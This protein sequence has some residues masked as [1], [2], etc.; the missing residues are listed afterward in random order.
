MKIQEK[1]MQDLQIKKPKYELDINKVGVTGLLLP[2]KIKYNGQVNPVTANISAFVDLPKTE[3][4]TH[5]SRMIKILH[6]AS[7][8][9]LDPDEISN[10][11]KELKNQL[12]AHHSYLKIEFTLFKAKKSPVTKNEGFI[13]YKC[14]FNADQNA[15]MN[16]RL[17]AEVLVTSL[18]PIS[19]SVS[20]YSAHNQ[21]GKLIAEVLCNDKGIW[22]D[23]II[24]TLENGGS[25][26]L[27][28]VLKRE[29]E[30]YVTEKAYENPKIVE[31]IVREVASE[32]KK[33]KHIMELRVSC[34]NFESI[35]THN[36]YSEITLKNG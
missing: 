25:C 1:Q 31:D 7:S 4:G 27:F 26:E 20:K 35:H 21:R 9:E 13:S 30:K 14:F 34:E 32:L 2:L 33:N 16:L 18:C 23:E 24:D 17:G 3:R 28:S 19:K 36:A 8:K 29:D 22:F 11:L 10:I 6:N 12:N 5:M 15:V